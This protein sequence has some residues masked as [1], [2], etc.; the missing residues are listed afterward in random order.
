MAGRR[1]ARRQSATVRRLA[2]IQPPV[3]PGFP[4][5]PFPVEPLSLLALAGLTPRTG[6]YCR[7]LDGARCADPARL[8]DPRASAACLSVVTATAHHAWAIAA[9][10]RRLGIPVIVGGMLASLDPEDCLA[11]ADC[12]VEGEVEGRWEG[13][14]AD[15]AAGRLARRYR[16]GPAERFDQVIRRDLLPRWRYPVLRL[17]QGSRG[18]PH[19]CEFCAPTAVNGRRQRHR[20]IP[21][22]VAELRELR[23]QSGPLVVGFTDDNLVADRAWAREL[24]TAIRPLGIRW[25]SQTCLDVA[26]DPELLDLAVA[27]GCMSLFVGL[28]SPRRRVLDALGKPQDPAGYADLVGRLQRRS[29]LV[30]GT[31]TLGHD[32]DDEGIYDEILADVRRTRIDYPLFIALMAHPGLPL[33][34]RLKT[35]GRLRDDPAGI[36]P[37]R[38]AFQPRVLNPERLPERLARLYAAAYGWGWI[39]RNLTYWFLRGRWLRVLYLAIFYCAYWSF[40][41]RASRPVGQDR[42]GTN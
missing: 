35:E 15:L 42:P 8:V 25:A 3:N 9:R 40:V 21:S 6:W 31:Y 38:L 10:Y 19:G 37:F 18:C 41:G 28:E 7:I 5:V 13:I 34:R 24:F 1:T 17:V 11:H 30:I 16:L 36:H 12:V 32:D 20:S 2:L 23:R 22:I 39:C 33:H 14:L 26:R 4:P 29:V 27:S